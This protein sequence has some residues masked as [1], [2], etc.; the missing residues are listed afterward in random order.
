[1]SDL[2]SGIYT[3]TSAPYKLAVG[4]HMVDDLSLRPKKVVALPEGVQ[5][6]SASILP[7]SD[8]HQRAMAYL[9]SVVDRGEAS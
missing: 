1:M 8:T 7:A 2:R 3:I 5:A 4:L 9:T 6:P